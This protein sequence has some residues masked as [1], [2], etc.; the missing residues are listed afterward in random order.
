MQVREQT[1][2]TSCVRVGDTRHSAANTES[3]EGRSAV[4]VPVCDLRTMEPSGTWI[5]SHAI[6]AVPLMAKAS[7]SSIPVGQ[8]RQTP[9]F[10]PPAADSLSLISLLV[11]K[12]RFCLSLNSRLTGT[13]LMTRMFRFTFAGRSRRGEPLNVA[14][15]SCSDTRDICVKFSWVKSMVSSAASKWG[16]GCPPTST[17][18]NVPACSSGARIR[19]RSPPGG[20]FFE[21][22]RAS[23]TFP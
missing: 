2:P 8:S 12:R 23:V 15:I 9:L 7:T 20:T 6:H 19:S 21:K 3:V 10:L 22:D 14:T 17:W 18:L 11:L 1:C 4:V 13:L 5:S 16:H